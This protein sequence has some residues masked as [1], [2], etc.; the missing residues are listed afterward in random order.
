MKSNTRK[1]KEEKMIVAAEKVFFSLGYANTKMEDIARQASCS[2]TTLYTYFE[3]KENLYM[4]ITYRAFQALMEVYY[5]T[6]NTCLNKP[7]FERVAA[8]FKAYLDFSEKQF[9]YQQLLLE[10]LTFIRSTSG[11]QHQIK[12]TDALKKSLWFRKVQDLH[13][14]PLT[15]MIQHIREGQLDGSIHNKNQPEEIYL[16]IWALLIGYTKLS[17]TSPESKSNTLFQVNLKTWKEKVLTLMEHILL[18]TK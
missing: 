7:G 5:E 17:F 1:L 4:A 6:L 11:K 10:Y 14:Q 2:K 8:I 3:S 15:V 13:N 12:L 18:T 16:T 9:D